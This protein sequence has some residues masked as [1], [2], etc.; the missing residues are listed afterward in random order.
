MPPNI[1][2]GHVFAALPLT[3]HWRRSLHNL[4]D[5]LT[6]EDRTLAATITSKEWVLP[7][8]KILDQDGKSHCVGDGWI[9]FL[10][11]P[12]YEHD[13]TQ[14]DADALYYEAVAI[15][16]VPHSEDGA[17]TEWGAK[18]V[19][20]RKRATGYA[21]ANSI[22]DIITWLLVKGPLVTGLVWTT[23]M[24]DPDS[25][26]LMHATG[27]IIGGHE[28]CWNGVDKNTGRL[29]MPNSWGFDWAQAGFAYLSLDDMAKRLDYMGDCCTMVE[30]PLPGATMSKLGI[31][32]I[33]TGDLPVDWFAK[34]HP[35]NAVSM[36]HNPS[37]WQSVKAASLTTEIIGR[38]YLE[39]SQQQFGNPV[40]DAQAFYNRMLPSANAM[41]NV[42]AYW[43]AYNEPVL[44]NEQDARNLSAFTVEWSRLMHAAGFKT[45]AYSFSVGNPQ[46]AY[47]PLLA[48]GIRACDGLALHEYSAP[49]MDAQQS[50]LCLRYRQV[51]TW[52]PAD[53]KQVPIWITE[54]GIDGGPIGQPQQGWAHFG[55]EAHYLSSLRWY[56][57]EIVKDPQVR[58][59]TIFAA[60]WDTAPTF[61]MGQCNS[62]RDYI[63]ASLPPPP[64]PPPPL[65]VPTYELTADKTTISA[66]E[67]VT[68]SW[69]TSA[70]SKEYLDGE[71]IAGD[72][73]TRQ[74]KP[75]ETHGYILQVVL[76]DGTMKTVT[77]VVTV[78]QP[79][80]QTFDQAAWANIAPLMPIN[81]QAWLY[82]Y[83]KT[84]LKNPMPQTEEDRFT[85]GGKTYARQVFN[86]E[87]SPFGGVVWCE[88]GHWDAAH[89]GLVPKPV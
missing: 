12:P 35:C 54:C 32:L 27:S 66:G 71:S 70:I 72:Y 5:Y 36:D 18:A 43:T 34:A 14:A 33:N 79:P 78:V 24:E 29:K 7:P 76:L 50:W 75:V 77:V 37:Y 57:S 68:L 10:N 60:K 21:W 86:A 15:G 22:D 9:T 11:C 8:K 2:K 42:Y 31:Y 59:A 82:Q 3:Q 1:Y 45:L 38:Y 49:T 4:G 58:G 81:T 48:D 51:L 69:H 89:S 65:P 83:A 25:S 20:A 84:I 41:R 17:E 63:G 44:N 62:I 46:L 19:V 80:Q 26:G 67:T 53:L 39:E 30:L 88:D 16:G 28:T 13:Y 73:G 56:D 52:L 64:P 61:D 85:F 47:W 55:D 74:F 23:G 40:A 87:Q 6:D